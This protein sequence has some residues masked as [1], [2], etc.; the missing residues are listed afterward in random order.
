[1]GYAGNP[2]TKCPS[3]CDH[4][5]CNDDF[6]C[7]TCSPGFYDDFCNQTCSEHCLNNTCNRDGRCKC[8]VGYGGH[9][10]EP[11]PK[12]CGDAGC[13][14]QLMC[15][16]CDP[17]FY[18]DYCNF[19]CSANCINGTCNR[20]GSCTCKKGFDGFGCCPEYCDGGCN[21][22]TFVCSLCKEGYY[23]DFCTERCPDNCKNGCTRDEGICNKC[24]RGYWGE[25]CDKGKKY[26]NFNLILQCRIIQSKIII[27]HH[28]CSL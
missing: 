28:K 25:T 23:G 8:N 9:P 19:T 22:R 18:G 11:C 3:N 12:N 2:C 6:Y 14:K 13:N 7:Y 24:T 27:Q 17:G 20:D 10:C 1:M 21:G 26:L 5:G 4:T 16:E 15:H